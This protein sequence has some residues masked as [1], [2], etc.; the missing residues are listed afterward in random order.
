MKKKY[1]LLKLK[2]NSDA[3]ED[4]YWGNELFAVSLDFN[5]SKPPEFD[6]EKELSNFDADYIFSNYGI[7]KD[8]LCN[9][10]LLK[11]LCRENG[12]EIRWAN[13]FTIHHTLFLFKTIMCVILINNK[14]IYDI[15][16][17]YKVFELRFTIEPKFLEKLENFI[18]YIFA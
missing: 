9:F 3:E 18:S 12:D 15:L 1:K 7:N 10:I 4:G 8:V 5:T 6:F 17:T 16:I 2:N 11:Q 13:G 14:P